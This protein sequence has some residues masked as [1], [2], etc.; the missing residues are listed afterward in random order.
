MSMVLPLISERLHDQHGE[1]EE[2]ENHP[3]HHAAGAVGGRCGAGGEQHDP[4]ENL[5]S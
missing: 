4:E 1:G 3:G 5:Q 2:P